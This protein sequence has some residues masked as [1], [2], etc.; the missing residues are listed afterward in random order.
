MVKLEQIVALGT[1]RFKE[2]GCSL[3]FGDSSY[4]FPCLFGFSNGFQQRI[5]LLRS[6][7]AYKYIKELLFCLHF[8]TVVFG[9]FYSATK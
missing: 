9:R 7:T 2:H 5:R 4:R 1:H 6:K 3:F 8:L